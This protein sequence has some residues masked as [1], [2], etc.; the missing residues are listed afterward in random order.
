MCTQDGLYI[1]F[2]EEPSSGMMAALTRKEKT[3][4][5]TKPLVYWLRLMADS[6]LYEEWERWKQWWHS[7]VDGHILAAEPTLPLHCTLMFDQDQSHKDY[8]T[9][10]DELINK[11]EYHAL[12][13]NIYIGPQGAAAAVFLQP[14]LQEWF[15]VKGSTPHVTLVVADGY[16][17]HDLGPMMKTA[18]QAKWMPSKTGCDN[19][20][21]SED[22]QFMKLRVEMYV[23]GLAE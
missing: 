9:C 4:T 7:S 10:W 16:E 17:S 2:P 1:D 12:I 21:F 5:L 13:K 6:N 15:Q 11:K 20:Q 22:R 8:E 19:V 14:D 23:E 18:L 3:E